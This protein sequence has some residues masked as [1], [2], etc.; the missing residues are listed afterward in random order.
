MRFKIKTEADAFRKWDVVRCYGSNRTAWVIKK[1]K[2][3]HSIEL[4]LSKMPTNKFIRFIKLWSR[5]SL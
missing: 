5:R 1:E 4:T 3:D 2:G